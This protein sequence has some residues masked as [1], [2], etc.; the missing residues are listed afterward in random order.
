MYYAYNPIPSVSAGVRAWA[1]TCTEGDAPTGLCVQGRISRVLAV[2]VPCVGQVIIVLTAC[3]VEPW[4]A[5]LVRAL[6]ISRETQASALANL[7]FV[8]PHVV[9]ARVILILNKTARVLNPFSTH[10][11]L[12]P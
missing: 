6:V 7:N 9:L 4:F 5:P 2:T 12:W 8:G 3:R 1:T 10:V 11:R